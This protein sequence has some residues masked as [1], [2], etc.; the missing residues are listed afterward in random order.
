M[1]T[2]VWFVL[3][4]AAN[5]R[6]WILRENDAPSLSVSPHYFRYCQKAFFDQSGFAKHKR[7]H[8]GERAITCGFYRNIF[9]HKVDSTKDS[10]RVSGCSTASSAA[11]ILCSGQ[12]CT[13]TFSWCTAASDQSPAS[14]ARKCQVSHRCWRLARRLTHDSSQWCWQSLHHK[15]QSI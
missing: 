2:M 1:H 7:I 15:L 5:F 14:Y 9:M 8:T 10:T 11:S 3:E 4:L 13:N 12:S 6:Y